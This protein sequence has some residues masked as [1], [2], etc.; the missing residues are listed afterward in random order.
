MKHKRNKKPLVTTKHGRSR[1]RQRTGISGGNSEKM[2]KRILR[3]GIKHSETSGELH[4]YM[5]QVYL[6]HQNSNNSRIYGDCIYLF[7]GNKMITV[8]KLPVHL[9]ENLE[10]Y[11]NAD[12]YNRY[13]QFRKQREKHKEEGQFKKE[14][15]KHKSYGKGANRTYGKNQLCKTHTPQ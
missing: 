5:S 14:R 13:I 7:G 2:A 1:M 12:T 9:Y 15:T 6:K 10:Q 4:S 8:F 11:V 3:A